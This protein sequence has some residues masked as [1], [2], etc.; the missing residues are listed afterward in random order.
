MM[1]DAAQDRFDQAIAAGRRP[2][3]FMFQPNKFEA[4]TPELA[5]WESSIAGA[6]SAFLRGKALAARAPA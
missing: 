3:V 5:E 6:F 1:A 4:V 2:A